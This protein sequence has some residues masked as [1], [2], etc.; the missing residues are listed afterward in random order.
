MYIKPLSFS[1]FRSINVSKTSRNHQQLTC[2]ESSSL[3]VQN[4]TTWSRSIFIP[5]SF[6]VCP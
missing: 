3:S 5:T 2:N 4:Y 1:I 6:D